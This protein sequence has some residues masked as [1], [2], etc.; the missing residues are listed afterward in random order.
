MGLDPSSTYSASLIIENE[1]S[2][3]ISIIDPLFGGGF[4]KESA[5]M[6]PHYLAET[7]LKVGS[8]LELLQGFVERSEAVTFI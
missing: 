1:S 6:V 3:V 8:F 4:F 2:A 7:D 5:Q